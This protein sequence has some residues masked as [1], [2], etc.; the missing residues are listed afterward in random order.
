[1]ATLIEK[2]HSV[3]TMRIVLDIVKRVLKALRVD[4]ES[5]SLPLKIGSS[6][7]YWL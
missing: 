7:C 1:M 3:Y 4:G 6:I 5:L 2:T